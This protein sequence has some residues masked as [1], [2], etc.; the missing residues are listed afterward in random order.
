VTWSLTS[1]ALHRGDRNL[2][3][4]KTMSTIQP[5]PAPAA[6]RPTTALLRRW[7]IAVGLLAAALAFV[8][9]GDRETVITALFV[10]LACYLAAAALD[11]P[12]VAWAAGQ[13]AVVAVTAGQFLD[14][15]PWFVIGGASV[16]LILAGLLR[17]ASQPALTAQSLAML[18]Y[19]GAAVLGLAF[20]P[21]VGAVLASLALIAHAGWDVFHYR[22]NAV[23]PRSLAEFCMFF[24]IPLGVAVIVLVLAGG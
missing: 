1:F 18:G 11:R 15:D 6:A 20:S 16:V 13:I 14:I 9:G 2:L 23:V 17:G 8:A 4:R 5:A 7:P 19:G 12:W 10:A 21:V 3:R 24:D 22:K